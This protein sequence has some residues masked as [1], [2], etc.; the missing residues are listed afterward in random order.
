MRVVGWLTASAVK[1]S[2]VV[3]EATVSRSPCKIVPF[4]VISFRTG[5]V[6]VIDILTET[7]RVPR[8]CCFHRVIVVLLGLRLFMVP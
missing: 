1:A 6:V 5:E 8:S 7:G 4:D 2:A 3:A